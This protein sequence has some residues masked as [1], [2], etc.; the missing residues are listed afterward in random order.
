MGGAGGAVGGAAVDETNGLVP[1]SGIFS[2]AFCDWFLVGGG[3]VDGMSGLATE[4]RKGGASSPPPREE[5]VGVMA[6]KKIDRA[7]VA[8][9]RNDT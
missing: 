7:C 6:E 8:P 5:G 9:R 2:P 3:A 4:K 1:A